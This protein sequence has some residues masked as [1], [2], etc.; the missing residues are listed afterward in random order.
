MP[1]YNYYSSKCD[2]NYGDLRKYEER[3]EKLT[4]P[5][6]GKRQCPLTYD[7]SKNAKKGGGMGIRVQGGTPN[8]HQNETLNKKYAKEWYEAEIDNTKDALDSI[9]G[10]ESPYARYTMDHEKLCESGV[11]KR[12]SDKKGKQKKKAAERLA[13][14]H[15]KNISENDKKYVGSRHKG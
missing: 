2:A 3:N 8:F 12:V 1:N 11:L 5:E 6:C 13:K 7:C 4:C 15:A 14:M 10:G 9:N